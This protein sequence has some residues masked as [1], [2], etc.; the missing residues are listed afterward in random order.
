MDT[1]MILTVLHL[2]I[3][4]YKCGAKVIGSVRDGDNS[5]IGANAVVVKD[6]PEN[7]TVIMFQHIS[8][9]GIA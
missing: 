2:V 1:Q 4:V 5:I 9:A 8:Y 7:C 6:V 3:N